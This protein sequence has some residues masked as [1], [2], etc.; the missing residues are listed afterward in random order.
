[1]RV[2]VTGVSG[3][4][5]SHIARGLAREGHGVI[6]LVRASSPRDHVADAVERFVVGDHAEPAARDEAIADADAVVHNSLDRGS[7]TG[8]LDAYLQRNLVA[9]IQWLEA[10][11]PRPFVFVSS[12][13]AVAD[14]LPSAGGRITPK[15][16]TRP[17]S[18]YGAYKAA[19][20]Q[21]CLAAH[22]GHGRRVT[23][24]RPSAVYGMDRTLERTHGHAIVNRLRETGR[25]DAPGG[26]KFV[27]VEDVAAVI[28]ASLE[29]ERADGAI[30]NLADCY[31]RWADWAQI[32]AEELGLDDA[33]IDR[34]SP[35]RP[36][37]QF[38]KSAVQA[39][40]VTMD[41]GHEGIRTH[42]RE[43]IGQMGAAS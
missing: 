40:G 16:P 5:G 31:A 20:E 32:A 38:D 26:G 28:A 25:F 19:V 27:H 34:S 37:N 39:L 23:I 33:R 11:A 9:S 6:G 17:K 42:L 2:L 15:H 8:D 35:P 7:A 14:I 24:V 43:L 36:Q 1:M 41:R 18:H 3:F 30:Y 21:F 12:V 13:A 29:Q 10:S 4:I 22:L